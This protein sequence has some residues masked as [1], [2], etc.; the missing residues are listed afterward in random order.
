MKDHSPD[1]R[2][3]TIWLD[4]D[5]RARLH[6]QANKSNQRMSELVRTYLEWGLETDEAQN[7]DRR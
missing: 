2:T 7:R 4:D 3:Y 5:L 1:T 6:A